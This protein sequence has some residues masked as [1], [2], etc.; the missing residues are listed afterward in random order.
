[1]SKDDGE[2]GHFFLDR[3]RDGEATGLFWEALFSLSHQIPP[4]S[5]DVISSRCEL[6]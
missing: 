5:T 4:N 1:M 3:E 2:E 6:H